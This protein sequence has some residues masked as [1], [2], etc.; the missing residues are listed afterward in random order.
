MNKKYTAEQLSASAEASTVAEE[1]FGSI[2]TVSGPTLSVQIAEHACSSGGPLH[3]FN[4][5]HFFRSTHSLEPGITRFQSVY[6]CS[7][8]SCCSGRAANVQQHKYTMTRLP[9]LDSFLPDLQGDPAV[10]C[11]A[12]GCKAI[13]CVFALILFLARSVVTACQC[14]Q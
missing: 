1:C 9:H 4:R 7:C 10:H 3:A 13:H 2:R 6:A 12:C 11:H 5:Y 14:S 8:D